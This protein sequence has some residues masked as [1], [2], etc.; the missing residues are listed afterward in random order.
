MKNIL[1]TIT[2]TFFKDQFLGDLVV[3]DIVYIVFEYEG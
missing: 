2:Y 3:E 1:M